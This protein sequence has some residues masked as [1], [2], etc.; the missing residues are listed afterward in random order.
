MFKVVK[1]LPMKGKSGHL[2]WQYQLRRDDSVP[3]PWTKAGKEQILLLDLQ[4]QVFIIFGIGY[5]LCL[6]YLMI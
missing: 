4:M 3:V 5:I 2:I 6:Y 1:Y